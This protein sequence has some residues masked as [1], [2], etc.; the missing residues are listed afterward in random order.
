M[1]LEILGILALA[2]LVAWIITLVI[3]AQKKE[4]IWFILT[5]L[6]NPVMIIYWIVKIFSK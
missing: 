3:Q 5:I 1:I 4:Y 2:Y 6:I